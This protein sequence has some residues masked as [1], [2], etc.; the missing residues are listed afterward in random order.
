MQTSNYT[1]TFAIRLTLLMC[2]EGFEHMI[3]L[4]IRVILWLQLSH[5]YI[6]KYINGGFFSLP[7]NHTSK[8]IL[9]KEFDWKRAGLVTHEKIGCNQ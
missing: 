4:V 3:W 5:H 2:E 6:K 7:I 1:V 9:K 8:K